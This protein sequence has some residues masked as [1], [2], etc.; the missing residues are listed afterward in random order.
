MLAALGSRWWFG[1]GFKKIV[2][3]CHSEYVM[4]G[5]SSW[6]LTWKK[7]EW[8]TNT[9]TVVENLDLWAY[10]NLRATCGHLRT[11]DRKC[12]ADAQKRSQVSQVSRRSAQRY[13]KCSARCRPTVNTGSMFV[14]T[15]YLPYD[16]IWR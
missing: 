11:G 7:N 3:A 13:I 14:I 6:I 15:V 16:Q 4:N 5:I 9:G 2:I 8:K 10:R 12:L 1:E